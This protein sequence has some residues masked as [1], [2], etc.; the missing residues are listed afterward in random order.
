MLNKIDYLRNT[1]FVKRETY[2]NRKRDNYKFS[3]EETT[4]AVEH[5]IETEQEP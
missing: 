3:K 4:L 2:W 1:F 5:Y